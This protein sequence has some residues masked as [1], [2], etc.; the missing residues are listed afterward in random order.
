[1]DTCM[2]TGTAIETVKREAWDVAY[3]AH[4]ICKP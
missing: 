4:G 1:M 2:P 3:L